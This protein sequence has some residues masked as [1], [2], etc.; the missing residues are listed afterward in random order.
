MLLSNGSYINNICGHNHS[1]VTNPNWVILP[2]TMFGYYNRRDPD[3]S[4]I[5][6][7]L[8]SDSLPTGT[9]S[10]YSLMIG[11]GG[12]LLSS[13]TTVTGIGTLSSD[14]SG[15]INL[16]SNLVG[17]GQLTADLQV[18]VNMA[19][20]LAGTGNID[21]ASLVG[22]VA[23][24]A[25]LAGTTTVTGSSDIIAFMI[26]VIQ[27][28][29]GISA[30]LSGKLSMSADIFVNQSEA[31]IKE[32]VDGVWNAVLSDYNDPNTM[33]EVMNN[34]G[35]VSD[36]WTTTL[37]GTYAPGEAGYILGNLLSNIPDSVWDEL[38]ASHTTNNSYGKIIQDLET[39][40]KQIKA[41]TSA[42]L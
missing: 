19:S 10:P 27:G 18:I 3:Y 16:L 39:I 25:T 14:A 32:L 6:T 1:G 36:P 28:T 30:N 11:F 22:S 13:T 21:S 8:E 33:G 15:G 31:T 7:Q 29:G 17:L 41:L 38:K 35:A 4:S 2:H 42:N 12:V 40:A 37:P 5:Y 26:S 9:N 23:L 34:M 24:A 20:A